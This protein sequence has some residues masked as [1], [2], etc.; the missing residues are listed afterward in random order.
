MLTDT[1]LKIAVVD[2][3]E[4]DRVQIT[5]MAKCILCNAKISHSIDCYA[6][7]KALLDDLHSGKNITSSC[8]MF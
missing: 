5:D 7:G 1:E 2:D 8:W 3:M 4:Q 6:D